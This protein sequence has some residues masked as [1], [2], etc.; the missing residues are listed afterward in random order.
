MKLDITRKSDLAV[1]ALCALGGQKERVKGSDLAELID[2]TTGFLP[3]V[4]APLVRRRWIKSTPGPSGGYMLDV[5]LATISLL[6]VIE[7]V[8]GPLDADVCV[9]DGGHCT[10]TNRCV[11]HDAWSSAREQLYAELATTPISQTSP[12]GE[13]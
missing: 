10:G 12:R 4:L 3:Q 9:L 13:A 6:D 11:I 7:A 2:T 1:R 8:E 5:D